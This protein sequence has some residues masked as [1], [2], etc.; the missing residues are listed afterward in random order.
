MTMRWAKLS[1][2]VLLAGCAVSNPPGLDWPQWRGARRDGVWRENGILEKFTA[3]RLAL[4]WSTPVGGGYSGPTVAAGRVYLTDRLTEPTEVERVLCFDWATGANLWSVTYDCVYADFEYK[5][6]PRASVTVHEGRA[7]A[8]GSAGHLHALDAADGRVLWKRDLRR[9]HQIRMPEWGIAASPLIEGDTIITQIGGAGEGCVIGLDLRTGQDRWRALPDKAAY[10][11]PIAVEQAGRRVVILCLADRVVG[12]APETG[13]LLWSYEMPGSTWP[14]TIAT[15]VIQG[16]LLFVTTAH[17]GAALLR[18]RA[19]AP[20]VEE[21]WRRDGRKSRSADTLHSVIP[22]PL[23]MN[24]QIFGVHGRG[25]LR[26]LELMTGRRLW[27]ETRA[28]PADTHAT[29][30]LVRHGD[31]G[32]RVWIFNER[33]ELILAR[34]T[35]A[36]YEELTRAKL[37]EP[38][39]L[40]LPRGVTWSHP[41]FAYRHVFARSDRELVCADLSAGGTR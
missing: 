11:A 32:D 10:A 39:R 38:T 24:G 35:G 1:G 25:E 6:G 7:Y 12:L 3:E 30:H 41:A 5:A 9:E 21:V 4:R 2:A 15:P 33:G 13:A 17:V 16:D 14:I 28:M 8:L 20:A 23:L 26:C 29:M 37:I 22:T 31:A 18:L 40:Q 36:G 19:D 27:E 34:L